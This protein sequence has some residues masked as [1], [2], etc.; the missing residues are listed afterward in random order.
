MIDA[1]YWLLAGV[2]MGMVVMAFLTIGT[3]QRGYAEGYLLRRPWRAE[4]QARRS[5][6]IRANRRAMAF[7]ASRYAPEGP[8]ER[9][10]RVAVNG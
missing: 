8:R 7:G 6:V 1:S 10:D 4:L 3:Y 9:T 2:L 5:A